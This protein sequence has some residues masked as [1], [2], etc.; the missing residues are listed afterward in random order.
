MLIAVFLATPGCWKK[1]EPLRI[2]LGKG[3]IL[4]LSEEWSLKKTALKSSIKI[5][6]MTR[7]EGIEINA[8]VSTARKI[9]FGRQVE[10]DRN[11]LN[12]K[13]GYSILIEK[14]HEI[15]GYPAYIFIVTSVEQGKRFKSRVILFQKDDTLFYVTLKAEIDKFEGAI[16]DFKQMMESI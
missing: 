12:L 1:K 6:T 13:K 2:S 15:R 8:T 11:N 7:G 3:I 16:N 14:N 4:N 10:Q 9:P 5:Y